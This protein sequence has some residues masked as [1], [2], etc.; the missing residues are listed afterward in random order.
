MNGKDGET[1]PLTA[2]AR[3]AEVAVLAGGRFSGVDDLL[4]KHP[5]GY[6]YHSPR[7]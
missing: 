2:G 4:L 1:G 7:D 5:G 6:T 3:Q